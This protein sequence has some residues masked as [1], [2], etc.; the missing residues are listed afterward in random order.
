MISYLRFDC[1]FL[2]KHTLYIVFWGIDP[3]LIDAIILYLKN[4]S[5][6]DLETIIIYFL[7]TKIQTSPRQGNRGPAF[8]LLYLMHSPWP[9]ST[10]NSVTEN[11]CTYTKLFVQ[12]LNTMS[13]LLQLFYL[14]YH[15]LL[16]LTF[17][18]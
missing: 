14:S 3:S 12:R 1:N 13:L 7:M 4:N 11:K 6:W 9:F 8:A 10:L 18:C 15:F 5:I 16:F 17:G 2:Y